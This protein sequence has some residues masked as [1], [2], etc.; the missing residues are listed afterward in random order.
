MPYMSISQQVKGTKAKTTITK[1][2]IDTSKNINIRLSD[3]LILT[4]S[5]LNGINRSLNNQ[6]S[7]NDNQKDSNY[8][9]RTKSAIKTKVKYSADDSIVYTET[10]KIVYLF[11]N[12]QVNYG[13]LTNK[14]E[15][16]EI[17]LNKNTFKSYGKEDSTGELVGTP[18]F[19]Q[20]GTEYKAQEITYNF[21]T[22]KGYLKEFKTKEGEGY[23]R[24]Q[25]VKRDQENNFYI[26][27]AY[28]TTC[29]QIDDPHFYIEASKLKVVPGKKDITGP[30]RIVFE[31]IR[32]PPILPF[33]IFPLKRGQQS[34][35]IIPAYGFSPGRGYF[36]NRGGYYFGLSDK[37]DLSVTG[38]VW[39]NLSFAGRLNTRYANRYRYG[40]NLSFEYFKNKNGNVEDPTYNENTQFNFV[41]SHRMDQKA[42]P[43][44][45]FSANVNLVSANYYAQNS[46]NRN[47]LGFANTITS[48]ISYSKSF[49]KG[50]YNLSTN[51]R[52]SQNTQTRDLS[53]T[54]PDVNFTISSFQPFKPK[55]KPTADKWYENISTN[56]TGSISGTIS[57]KDS[58]LLRNRTQSQW[59]NYLD[60]TYRYS[61]NHAIPLQT[62]FKL[63]KYY[64]LST[65]VNYRESWTFQTIR[66]DIEDTGE[67]KNQ[68]ITRKV[69]EFGRAY[70][71]GTS[72][73]LS[74]RWYGQLNFSKGKVA[75]IRHVIN[76][77]FGFSFTPDFSDAMWGMYKT[78]KDST[79]KEH[80]YSIFEGTGANAPGIGKQ[81]NITFGF[82]NNLELKVR[83]GKD[84]AMKEEKIK[85]FESISINGSYNIFADSM[86]FST[87]S[88][89]AFTT[90]FK[91]V[92]L[93]FN[94]I[95]DP[96][97]NVVVNKVAYNTINVVRVNRLYI[98]EFG[99][100]GRITTANIGASFSLSPETFKKLQKHKTERNKEMEKMGYTVFNI[101]WSMAF[102]YTLS[103]DA[104]APYSYYPR[105]S[106][107]QTLGVSGSVTPTKNWNFG[108]S[109]GYDFVNHKISSLSLD[110]K[111]DLHCWMFTFNWMP[112]A[113]SGYQYFIFEI[114]AKASMLQDL[115]L[116]PRRREW[117]DRKI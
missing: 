84:T 116:P 82:D 81:G 55:W 117:F 27:D 104:N 93:R 60:T 61:I 64:T 65:S 10:N 2:S 3:S 69:K 30:A 4:K 46:F 23:I 48:G 13:D 31:G 34:G 38:D 112:I 12:A 35:V 44:V 72:A 96:Y 75:A 114:R 43:N 7:T 49:A 9:P 110:L 26:R 42:R 37:F 63:F 32:T 36:L 33:G 109:S 94:S 68:I 107:I 47:N 77:N 41:W 53:I 103:Y 97:V 56:Y 99:V 115:K 40:G 62:S 92:Q 105:N 89:N 54:L 8:L 70:S 18:Q 101:P 29:D 52:I 39:T 15:I 88:F 67:L 98:N 66:K 73:S 102:N 113:P 6:D 95:I 87:F 106:Y 59:I 21:S 5:N 83:R 24:G 50:K 28:Y 90:I 108:Y 45:N 22:N 86:R 71:F 14:S 100:L 91:N 58:L 11:G 76:P 74:T 17:D 85:L 20:G 19:K 78:Y 57:T 111:R 51:T 1:A 25:K 80:K 79:G 16:L